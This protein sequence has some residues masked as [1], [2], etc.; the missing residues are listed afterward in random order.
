MLVVLGGLF[1]WVPALLG[2]GGSVLPWLAGERLRE[3]DDAG[4][5]VRG[6]LGFLVLGT[7]GAALN[8]FAG[9]GPML[10]AAAALAGLALFARA[11]RR[12]LGPLGR[13]DAF[14]LVGLAALLAFVASGPIRHYD[15]G[16]YHLQALSWSRAGPLPAGLANLHRRFGL[17]SL[18]DPA[19]ALL[20]LPG[21]DGRGASLAPPLVLFLFGTAVWRAGRRA[22]TGRPDAATI[23]LALGAVPL[24]VLA[25]NGSV[26]SLSTDLPAAALTILSAHFLLRPSSTRSER[27][28]A[29]ALALFAVLV[30][31]SAAVWFLA[32]LLI[33]R[34]FPVGLL[35]PALAW[36]MRGI[37]LSG[38]VVYPA[39]VSRIG[40]LPWAAPAAIA[41]EEIDRARSW[42]RLP[43]GLPADESGGWA[44]LGPWAKSTTTRVSMLPL[45]LLLLLGLVTFFLAR[46][47]P[48]EP[49][50]ARPFVVTLAAAIASTLFWLWSA[51][52]PRLGY[53]ALFVLAA[54][55]LSASLPR[56][57]LGA[58]P[59]ALR[60]LLAG[61]AAALLLLAG[62]VRLSHAGPWRP[63]A[64]VPAAAPRAVVEAR[65]TREGETVFVPVGDDRCWDAPRPCTPFFASDLVIERDLHGRPRV[66]WHPPAAPVTGGVGEK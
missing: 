62:A 60:T 40:L 22:V 4:L 15:T 64:L 25:T 47:R 59:P 30:K 56:L 8:A 20:E 33:V 61:G 13:T 7:I 46:R 34:T 51:P 45:V 26:P 1:L 38:Y 27:G 53:G 37:T 32:V 10:S 52:D 65:L 55:P 66:F 14:A 11:P 42:A 31:L 29:L 48:A 18:W 23:L 2:W 24:A 28:A 41:R 3:E 50:A 16:L 58:S 5:A 54:L 12:N 49:E 36:A 9:L 43:H 19:A 21:L 17:D 39:L 6:F 57:G 35:L 63:A 44:W